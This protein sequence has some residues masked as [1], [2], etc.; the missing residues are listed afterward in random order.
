MHK[1]LVCSE[2]CYGQSHDE[3][4]CLQKACRDG[5]WSNW[6]R[7]STCSL[8]CG[9]GIQTRSRSCTNPKPSVGGQYCTG[10][11]L[12][13]QSCNI[14]RCPIDGNWTHWST[15]SSCDVSCDNGTQI[16]TRTCTHPPSANGGADCIGQNT[17][18]MPCIKDLCPV[19]GGW[20]TWSGWG[21]CSS[22]CDFGI[23]RRNR[24]CSNPYPSSFGEHCFGESRDDRVCLQPACS[25]GGWTNWDSWS[26]CSMTCGGG[27]QSRSRTC[28][29]PRPSVLG[30]DCIGNPCETKTCN[31]ERCPPVVSAFS[32]DTPLSYSRFNGTNKLTFSHVIYQHGGDFS[33]AT[34]TFM[35]S[36]PGVYPFIVTLVKKRSSA[37][38][39]QVYCDLKN[40]RSQIIHIQVDPTDDDSDKGSAA[41]T[42]S[43]I[44]HLNRGGTNTF[45]DEDYSDVKDKISEVASTMPEVSCE[46]QVEVP[47]IVNHDRR[48]IR[49]SPFL[50][51]LLGLLIF[52]HLGCYA[53]ECY[54]CQSV[55][56]A[57][58]CNKTVHC[59]SGESCSMVSAQPTLQGTNQ[60][61]MGCLE[62]QRCGI[63]S[64]AGIPVGKRQTNCDECCS[65][66][67]CNSRL[68]SHLQPT[69]CVDDYSE[70]CARLHSLFQICKD[71]AHAKLICP[72]FCG[73]CNVV[74]GNW[75][76][77][78]SW[79]S[80]DVTC[81]NGTQVRTR[82][83]TDPAPEHG[84]ANCTGQHSQ[85]MQC[86]KDLCPVH[87]GWSTWSD[88]GSCSSTCDFGI[89]TRDRSC[90]NPYPSLFGNHC[91]GESRDDRIC[92][93][94]PCANGGWTD[95]ENWSTCSV[96]CGGGIQSRSRSCTNPKPSIL[97][98]YCIGDEQQTQTCNNTRCQPLVSAFS[99]DHP[100]SYS[101]FSG[102]AKL[103][104]NNTIYQHGGDFNRSTGTFT[105][106][107]PGTYHF[108]VTLVKK[109]AGTRVDQA[110]CT[111]YKDQSTLIYLRIDPTDDDTDKG[112]AAI[113]Q[114][115]VTHLNKGNTVY[116]GSCTG[117]LPNTYMEYHSS[118]TGF[119]LYPDNIRILCND[120]NI[121]SGMLNLSVTILGLFYL[122]V[123]YK[124]H[125][126]VVLVCLIMELQ[127]TA[128]SD[129]RASK[130]GIYEN[131]VVSNASV[132]LTERQHTRQTEQ[133][134]GQYEQLRIETKSDDREKKDT[135]RDKN[136]LKCVIYVTV[137]M[138]I[139]LYIIVI[140]TIIILARQTWQVDGIWAQWSNWTSCDV[141]CG[142]GTQM[143]TRT[144]ANPA[145]SNG[146]NDCIG[147][148]VE[149]VPCTRDLCAVESG[150][151][152]WSDWSSCS[153]TCDIVI[154]VLS[155]RVL[156]S[157]NG[158]WAHWEGWST[159]SV[160]C[161]GGI[162]SRSRSCTNPK[163][164]ILGQYC[165][166]DAQ[167]TKTC[168]STRCRNGGWTNWGSW[169]T[170]SQTCGGGIYS[171][172]RTCTN[173]KPSDGGEYCI[174]NSLQTLSCSTKRC[175]PLVSAFSVSNP[176]NYSSFHGTKKLT[177]SHTI[178]QHG[179]DFDKSTGTFICSIPGTYHFSVTLVKKRA[180]TRVDYVF[181]LLY[182]SASDLINISVDP[183]DDDTDKG[184]AAISQSVVIHLYKGNTVYLGACN[185]QPSTYMEYWSSFTG[186]LLYPDN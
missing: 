125:V 160:S 105:C 95:W 118:F 76:H 133:E 130:P 128:S 82:T 64:T 127:D 34:G 168:D 23:Q 68:C 55:R 28:T 51:V 124:S 78:S 141:T 81:G 13:V 24:S 170:C 177:F 97:G 137:A 111:L 113:S 18:H 20:T 121:L 182:K 17:E 178:Y 44:I 60:F 162:Q 180:T 40:D 58:N 169:S 123:T 129:N 57:H 43:A 50:S 131:T 181:C 185:G 30:Q 165:I 21:S 184:S 15:W 101:N 73:L 46:A 146:G 84:G 22:T 126:F 112:S 153:S 63:A 79:T 8:T 47:P 26:A 186:F 83:C 33:L 172:S 85:T 62:N 71:I 122:R 106:S 103:T 110:F 154:R 39:D 29:K 92:L 90:S 27:M 35:C 75:A 14:S 45:N 115:I 117:P 167:Q 54:S 173:P 4:I 3:R 107:I 1:R 91:F 114:S 42:E 31:S 161:D 135:E 52:N 66:D 16:R 74:D 150:W 69:V 100:Y 138:L 56:G 12:H 174:G 163:P 155:S 119:L 147:N 38:V 96:S 5:R 140:I 32:V 6:E 183:T 25:N 157:R 120:M 67:L 36:K 134:E 9:G 176:Y 86:T 72:K 148:D 145:P 88:W 87:G 158:E 149:N 94:Q 80:C 7:W 109:R 132:E 179:G 61:S 77:W 108:S 99:V 104:F 171:R 70:D 116:L 156:Y 2:N 19:H 98:Q 53:L 166:G 143:R 151:A 102:T 159:C 49:R 93:Q 89:Q 175:P 139:V 41:I 142:N 59:N 37:R 11:P 10:D 65:S 136:R 144:C 164:S 48:K 152:T